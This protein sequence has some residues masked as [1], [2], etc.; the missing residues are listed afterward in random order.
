MLAHAECVGAAYGALVQTAEHYNGHLTY[1]ELAHYILNDSRI[2]YGAYQR[3]SI[4]E[5]LIAI[6][7]RNDTESWPLLTVL[8][9]SSAHERAS[10]GYAYAAKI[11]GSQSPR[12]CGRT[13][14]S[15]DCSTTASKAPGGRQAGQPIRHARL[16][17]NASGQGRP[18]TS[19][20]S[21]ARC[22]SAACCA[23]SLT[24]IDA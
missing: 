13:P 14:T 24:K 1:S 8:C 22:I 5:V 11:A 10:A 4:G 3:S 18:R 23:I 19:P 6:G 12:I 16:L 20:P 21:C 17:R 15:H 9:V 7:D 2:L